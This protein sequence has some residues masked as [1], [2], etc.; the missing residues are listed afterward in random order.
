MN[1]H[2][3][4]DRCWGDFLNLV[5]ESRPNPETVS[6]FQQALNRGQ[7]HLLEFQDANSLRVINPATEENVTCF[8]LE[9][10]PIYWR[11]AFSSLSPQFDNSEHSVNGC[12]PQVHRGMLA[13]LHADGQTLL[14][15]F[16]A[17]HNADY[18]ES[19][20]NLCHWLGILGGAI[21][22]K[23]NLLSQPR[24][25]EDSDVQL[26]RADF[27]A[28]VDG[29]D[30]V[31]YAKHVDGKY[32]FVNRKFE[33]IFDLQRKD[34]IGRTDEQVFASAPEL[35]KRFVENDRMVARLARSVQFEETAPHTDGPHQYVSVK[36]P[37][38]DRNGE[39]RAIAGI[40]TDITQ[41]AR[42]E[43]A[44]KHLQERDQEILN[45][46]ADGVVL[47]NQ[48][49]FVEY[50]NPAAKSLLKFSKREIKQSSFVSLVMSLDMS[51]TPR[52]ELLSPIHAALHSQCRTEAIE[53][54]FW[55]GSS[56]FLPVEYSVAP[57]I[58][59]GVPEGAV[60][61]FR[62]IR[63][64][65]DRRRDR[66]D[67]KAAQAVQRQLYPQT[68]PTLAGFDIAGA[69][70][71]AAA[72]SGD[73]YDYFVH[74]E[75]RLTLVVADASGHDLAAAMLMVN[76]RANLRAALKIEDDL[77]KVQQTVN[78]AL[79]EDHEDGKFVTTFLASLYASTQTM[80]YSGAGQ[81]AI[82]IPVEGE[83]APLK[84]GGLMLGVQNN[85]QLAGAV[86]L[87][88]NPGDIVL[89]C[90]DGL[91]DTM[92]PNRERLGRDRIVNFT[93]LHKDGTAHDILNALVQLA[94]EHA[95]FNWPQDDSTIVVVKTLAPGT[96][97]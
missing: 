94:K 45:A 70:F 85:L 29:T 28:I 48:K 58:D 64:R 49:G 33:Q 61:T 72:V 10:T 25:S 13:P 83:A 47:L 53:D 81:S 31:V 75:D 60:V 44:L 95:E 18:C 90:T 22:A 80:T 32:M 50:I 69:V 7:V 96:F 3:E 34:I 27:M 77:N 11:Q 35:A 89:I 12:F 43:H 42:A 82:Y 26:P 39:V 5:T 51:G 14:A 2:V 66:R 84:S 78:D 20:R 9:E 17:N 38:F 46:I 59:D 88:L 71:P 74:N 19:D 52:N 24:R 37:L 54:R 92:S 21:R 8:G 76:A 62:D 56:T 4:S 55:T 15:I 67:L 41:R 86:T 63:L 1:Q 91:E 57:I 73:Y 16:L 68:H 23:K 30:A 65:L 79:A 97:H 36:F 87:K 93:R 40:S 6:R